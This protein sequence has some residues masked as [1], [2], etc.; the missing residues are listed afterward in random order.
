VQKPFD[1]ET[2]LIIIEETLARADE[3]CDLQAEIQ[4]FRLRC[5]LLTQ[6]EREVLTLLIE[7]L[8][9]KL[10]AYRLGISTRTTEHHRAAVMQ[11]MQARTIS[12]LLRMALNLGH[13]NV[14]KNGAK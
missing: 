12:H 8:P 10:I 3:V 2:L 13:F 4:E 14:A 9:T 11:K 6:R 7:G 5:A 1:A